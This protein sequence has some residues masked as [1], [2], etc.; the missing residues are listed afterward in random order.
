MINAARELSRSCAALSF[1]A[2]VAV[3]YNPLDY[4]WHAHRWYLERMAQPGV[5]ALFVGLNPGP[6]GMVQT[7][8]PFGQVHA[9]RT[10]LGLEP[11]VARIRAPATQHPKR[12]VLGLACPR[13]EVSGARV[14]GWVE[15]RFGTPQAWAQH[16]FIWNWCPLA[17]MSTTGSNVTPDKLPPRSRAPLVLECDRALLRVA[18]HLRPTHVVGFGAFAHARAVAALQ[19]KVSAQFHQ[20]L[21]PSPASPAANKGWDRHMDAL[22]RTIGA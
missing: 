12:P 3:V 10:F 13:N 5:R 11:S 1:G 20:V 7:G 8:V 22:W 15:R 17:F 21:H 18:Q 14:W 4:A 16:A 19:G 6:F 9:V 2:P